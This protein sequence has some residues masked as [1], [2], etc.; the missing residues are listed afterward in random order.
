MHATVAL[1]KLPPM[2][3]VRTARQPRDE[4][5]SR[6]PQADLERIERGRGIR[7]DER[8]HGDEVRAAPIETNFADELVAD[9]VHVI[10]AGGGRR[11]RQELRHFPPFLDG[12]VCS[13]QHASQQVR[14]VDADEVVLLAPTKGGHGISDDRQYLRL[15][16]S[17]PEAIIGAGN[18]HVGHLDGAAGRGASAI[19]DV[20]VVDDVE[21]ALVQ[22]LRLATARIGPKHA[23]DRKALQV[24]KVAARDV[25]S[26]GLRQVERQLQQRAVGV[27]QANERVGQ[28]HGVLCAPGD[29]AAGSTCSQHALRGD[30]GE[31][32]GRLHARRHWRHGRRRQRH[33]TVSPERSHQ[34]PAHFL[35]AR[36]IHI[37]SSL[38]RIAR[39]C[40]HSAP[41][42]HATVERVIEREID[43]LP[44]HVA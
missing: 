6:T 26:E 13:L 29:H 22:L 17:A 1:L 10:R 12:H 20:H 24:D 44:R 4:H 38:A 2:T 14:V 37:R 16:H 19:T 30:L 41:T 23:T 32:V 43:L 3:A 5:R 35:P 15:R 11:G 42:V 33:R 18:R 34:P 7:R 27:Q 8:E 40:R 36:R 25:S 39:A 21:G 9:G 28:A 31:N